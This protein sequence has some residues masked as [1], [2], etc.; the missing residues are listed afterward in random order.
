MKDTLI[1]WCHHTLNF[2]LGCN[3][4]SAE[5]EGC[6]AKLLMARQ[7]EAFEVLRL[8]RGAWLE[9]DRL[10]AI[11]KARGT[12]EL[13][14][15]CS[16]SDFFHVQA[17]PWRDEAWDVIRGCRNLIWLVLTK[18]PE[19]I[20]EHLPPD[21]DAGKGFP[22]V[23]L[24]TTCGTRDSFKRVEM[25]RK[26][27]CALRFLSCEPLLEDISSIDLKG[28]HWILCGGMS[29]PLWRK[30]SMD[31]QWAA[32]LFDAAGRAKVPFLFKQVSDNKTERG[33]NALGLY[34]AHRAGKNPDP[35]TVD[36]VRQYPKT[37]L[38]FIQPQPKGQRWT[39]DEWSGVRGRTACSD[40]GLIATKP[41]LGTR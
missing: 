35:E 25:L 5:C 23:W 4:V 2:W 24:G 20:A 37:E 29:G 6:Y 28:I 9:A 40:P 8:T 27:P 32:S 15:T 22:H 1:G 17:D 13:V 7:G 34:L 18:R 11:A 10:N 19:R 30:K 31:L 33:I 39:R 38:S 12:H 26:I 14:F 21:W 3:K 41:P 16:M 36:C